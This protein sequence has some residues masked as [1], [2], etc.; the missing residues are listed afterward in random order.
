MPHMNGFETAT[1]IKQNPSSK[2]VPIIFVTAISK[3]PRYVY[4]G[5]ETG[6]V[7][8]IF[9]PFYP[10]VLKS[11]V[12]VFV[13]LFRKAQKIKR[14]AEELLESEERF[15]LLV[16]GVKDY[17]IYMLDPEGRVAT[18]SPS[19]ERMKGYTAPE[20]IGQPFSLFYPEEDRL[21]GK[22]QAVL[23]KAKQEGRAEDEGWRLHKDGRR[24]WANV[25]ITALYDKNGKLRGFG[26]VTRDFTERK[27]TE[28]ELHQKELELHQARKIE[29]VGRLAGGVAH[30]FNNLITGVLGISEDLKSQLRSSRPPP[31]GP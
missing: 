13:E 17:S 27:K 30:D 21:R 22:P 25:I 3:D 19:A 26:K 31:G 12:A 14:Q 11:K 2:D 20:I 23:E 9:K 8:Y 24:F 7:D 15:R 10:Q 6:A 4:Q 1:L 16:E 5:Y 28:E 18:W 29:A